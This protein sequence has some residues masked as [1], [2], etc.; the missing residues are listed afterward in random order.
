VRFWPGDP[1]FCDD[2]DVLASQLAAAAD[3]YRGRAPGSGD[4]PVSETKTRAKSPADVLDRLVGYLFDAED[5]CGSCAATRAGTPG[6][7]VAA[8]K[9]EDY[10]VAG[11][12]PGRHARA[13]GHDGPA[14]EDLQLGTGPAAPLRTTG[15]RACRRS[16]AG[17][18]SAALRGTRRFTITCAGRT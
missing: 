5:E 7:A 14:Q 12:A 9:V 15:P 17:A 8:P 18:G 11:R 6:P 13:R 10:R 16:G 2:L 1:L 3:G 4:G